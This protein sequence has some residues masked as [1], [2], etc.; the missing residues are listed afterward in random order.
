MEIKNFMNQEDSPLTK[1]YKRLD[2]LNIQIKHKEKEWD[3]A[4]DNNP[5]AIPEITK[6]L[7]KLETEKLNL[8]NY[9][10]AIEIGSSTEGSEPLI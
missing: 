9:I 1:A 4:D 5:Q 8:E 2:Q 3:R 10:T 7:E 6:D